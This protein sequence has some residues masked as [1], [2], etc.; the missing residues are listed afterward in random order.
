MTTVSTV[1]TP[2]IFGLLYA[3]DVWEALG[4]LVGL[5]PFYDAYGMGNQTPWVLL[6][7]GVALPFMVFAL[8]LWFSRGRGSG[9][10]RT[11]VFVVGYATVAALTL[12][13]SSI[14]Q[15]WRATALQAVLG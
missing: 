6:W 11:V 14:E 5:G 13:L 2:A 12:S 7:L 15:A 4:N 3:W 8:A 9:L 1:T 10:E